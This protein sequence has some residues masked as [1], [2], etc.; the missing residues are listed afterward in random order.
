MQFT[1]RGHVTHRH[2]RKLL[3]NIE[4]R[5]VGY[6]R[7]MNDRN[8]NQ[9]FLFTIKTSGKAILIFKRKLH[10][11]NH[12]RNRNTTFFFQHRNSRVKNRLIS[13]E[14]INNKALD[15][16]S[17]FFR[18]KHQGSQEL[19]KHPSTVNVPD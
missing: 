19:C 3:E 18:Q 2:L 13:P 6:S 1:D 10:I 16:F 5:K 4:I 15:P 11:R 7:V 14:F 12:S 8:I 17:F 9:P